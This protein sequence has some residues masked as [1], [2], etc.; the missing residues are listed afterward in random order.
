[1]SP[2]S[3]IQIYST[4]VVIK[5]PIAGPSGGALPRQFQYICSCRPGK[6]ATTCIPYCAMIIFYVQTLNIEECTVTNVGVAY[7]VHYRIVMWLEFSRMVMV[8]KWWG[9]LRL[10]LSLQPYAEHRWELSVFGSLST[11]QL[12]PMLSGLTLNLFIPDFVLQLW[13]TSLIFRI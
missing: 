4:G 2:S 6:E 12:M 7:S 13:R 8:T 1:M 5:G 10:W 11:L 3:S 9:G